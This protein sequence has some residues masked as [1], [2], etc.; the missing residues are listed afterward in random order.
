MMLFLKEQMRNIPEISKWRF[1]KNVS[2]YVAVRLL[3]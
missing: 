2:V 3:T 1:T